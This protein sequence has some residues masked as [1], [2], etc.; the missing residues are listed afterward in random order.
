MKKRT[1]K[2]IKKYALYAL[3]F[4]F[5]STILTAII[6]AFVPVPLTPYMVSRALTIKD[7]KINKTWVPIEKISP[8]LI[9]A[10]IAAEDQ[11]FLD[12][13]GFDFKAIRKAISNN[14]KGKRVKG[15]STISQQ[16][17]KNVFLWP[18]RSWIRKGMEVYFTTLIELFWSKKRTI[19]VYLNVVE[20]GKGI[21]GAQAASKH[22]FLKD[23]SKMNAYEA[24]MLAAILPSPIKYNLNHPDH[25]IFERQDWILEYM[26]KLRVQKK[27]KTFLQ[28][29]KN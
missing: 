14:S 21:Y 10:V 27:Y 6:Y 28:T 1:K 17:A 25:Y 4:F 18:A 29:I 19:E 22:Y 11:L 7:Y 2:R 26:F 9:L 12:H 24:A 16:T 5:G 8:Q 3:L 20:M 13:H 15:A 23:V